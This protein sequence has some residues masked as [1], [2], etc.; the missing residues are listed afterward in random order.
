V[1]YIAEDLGTLSPE[2]H[3]LREESGLPGMK[4]LELA[5]DGP[6]NDYLPHRHKRHC[7]C[8][9]GTH[10]N[11]TVV[12]WYTNA[13]EEEK[14]FVS[15][16]L[17][18]SETEAVRRAMLRCGQSS[19]ADLFV[20]QIQDYLGYGS[21]ARINVPGIAEDNWNWKLLSGKTTPELAEEI[22]ELT[23]TFGRCWKPAEKKEK[24]D[25]LESV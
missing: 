24:S 16:Y 22:C 5:F 10:D 1:S 2:V 14:A 23:H 25:L 12:G 18:A 7:I 9:T 15:R 19:V 8:Y 20:A 11:D 3:Q 6:G 4:V 21:E 17:G 13:P